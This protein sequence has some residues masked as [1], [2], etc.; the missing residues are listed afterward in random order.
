MQVS[1]TF[2]SEI[3]VGSPSSREVRSTGVTACISGSGLLIITSLLT[4]MSMST[5][6][7]GTQSMNPNMVLNGFLTQNAPSVWKRKLHTLWKLDYMG[8]VRGR[9]SFIE[10]P[11]RICPNQAM[12][13]EVTQAHYDSIKL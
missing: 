4:K 13:K 11:S 3:K 9:T 2:Q 1:S 7:I 8:S 5:V 6:S 10:S 12:L